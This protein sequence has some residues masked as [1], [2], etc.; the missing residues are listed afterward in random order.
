MCNIFN[1]SKTF[2]WSIIIIIENN[3]K[4]E[5]HTNITKSKYNLT[6]GIYICMYYY[7]NSKQ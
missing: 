4:V 7:N 5:I 6:L 3:N 2:S 1:L